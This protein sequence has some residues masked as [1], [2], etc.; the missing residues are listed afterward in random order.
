M[1]TV[2]ELPSRVRV[3]ENEWLPL[4]DGTRLAA[5]MWLPADAA[6][7]P[8]PALLE[9]LPYRKR[10]FMR[11]RDGPMHYYFAGHGYASIRVDIRGAG[12]SEGLTFDE[13]TERELDDAVAVIT[14]LAAQPWCNGSVG[15]FGISWGGFNS[16]QVAAR[17]PPALKAIITVASTDDR[18]ADDVHYMGGCLLAVDMLSWASI[19]LGFNA[20]PP[21]PAVVGE[22]WREQWLE[23]LERTPPFVEAWLAHQRRDAY[24][25]HGSVCED[26]AAI[27]CPV[28]AVGGWT[29][30]YTNA[31]PRLLERL[32]APR[33]GLIGPWAHGYPH[34]ARP[35][36]QIGF[37]QE[38]LRWWDY[39]LKG[40]DTGV[41]DEPTLRAWMTESVKP[42]SHHEALPGR[43]VAEPSWPPPEIT[44]QRLFLTDGGLRSAAAS[45]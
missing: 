5:R 22:R 44:P 42:A 32:T 17:R 3:V 38:M 27:E 35:G 31:I 4:S 19:M 21:D 15:M 20:R 9:Y 12:D 26:Y 8:V 1:K 34:F 33:K 30:A 23:R 40:I 10:D 43:W 14:W 18:Y 45:L 16:L 28:Y 29:D 11:G 25:K 7:R 6:H 24:W 39:W 37:L 2:A 13:Y 41:M 36:P